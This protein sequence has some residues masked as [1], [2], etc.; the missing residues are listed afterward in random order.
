LRNTNKNWS[1][2]K[3]RSKTRRLRR[4][5][6]KNKKYNKLLDLTTL[7]KFYYALLYVKLYLYKVR[8]IVPNN[9][10]I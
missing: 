5:E 8:P 1:R 10:K 3:I 2:G 6:C 7:W 9:I 4:K